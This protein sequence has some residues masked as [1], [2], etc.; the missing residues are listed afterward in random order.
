[1]RRSQELVIGCCCSAFLSFL[2]G[3]IILS[4]VLSDRAKYEAWKGLP[5][6][7]GDC[8]VVAAGLAYRGNCYQLIGTP[9]YSECTLSGGEVQ[10]QH[11]WT[12]NARE[13]STECM[14]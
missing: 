4:A 5:W 2:P 9:H 3:V 8:K 13:E 1:M 14:K 11:F 7:E 10:D 12:A 6:A